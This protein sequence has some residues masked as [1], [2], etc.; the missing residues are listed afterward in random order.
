M[1]DKSDWEAQEIETIYAEMEKGIALAKCRKCGCMRETLDQWLSALPTN[2]APEAI[3]LL[4]HTREWEREMQ[5]VQYACLGCAH[6][7]PAVAQNAFSQAFP[8]QSL[9]VL[10][11]DFRAGSAPWPVVIG[12]YLV[13][14]PSA[15]IAISTL[16]SAPLVNEL[17]GANP[18]G[19]AI[20]GK[21]ETENIG[22]D[23]VVKNVIANPALQYLILAGKESDGHQSGQALLA[24]AAT[25]ID[26]KG[27]I[28]GAKGKRPILR[29]VNAEEVRLFRDRIQVIDMIGSED[30]G[31][32]LARAEALVAEE[33]APCG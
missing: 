23:K 25:G 19:I 7:Y 20:I 18:Q 10:A 13:L 4:Q 16:A 29:N 33:P 17:A 31:A 30:S 28:I 14:N 6:C 15:P 26:D 21:T 1:I 9:A 12:E 32:I 22:I 8:E 27:R 24:L 11:C 3:D 2:S 5:P